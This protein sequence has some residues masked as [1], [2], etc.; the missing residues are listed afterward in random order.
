MEQ[1]LIQLIA[2]NILLV[3]SSNQLGELND[4]LRDHRMKID[5]IPLDDTDESISSRV[6]DKNFIHDP[7]TLKILQA[8]GVYTLSQLLDMGLQKFSSLPNI[9]KGRVVKLKSDLLRH[10][11]EDFG[12]VTLD[13]CIDNDFNTFN[14]IKYGILT[15]EEIS[16]LD[17]YCK[18]ALSYIETNCRLSSF[19]V[20]SY[21]NAINYRTLEA[22]RELS[23]MLEA[24][25][26][27]RTEQGKNM[28][29][30]IVPILTKLHDPEIIYATATA[31]KWWEE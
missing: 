10:G 29:K 12:P 27:R 23:D 1:E 28:F 15:R 26:L 3:K 31:N 21:M 11:I 20:D 7:S 16:Q 22:Y 2:K 6:L 25:K 19:T 9:G 18:W 13:E 8:Q 5:G 17:E 30:P 4:L 24:K 14:L